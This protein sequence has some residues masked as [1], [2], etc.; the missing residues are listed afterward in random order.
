MKEYLKEIE[1]NLEKNKFLGRVSA[2]YRD[3]YK[4]IVNNNEI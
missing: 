1:K 2:Q 4:V 3:I